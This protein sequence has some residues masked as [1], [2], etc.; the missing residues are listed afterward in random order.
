MDYSMIP[1]LN[2]SQTPTEADLIPKKFKG[3]VYMIVF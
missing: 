2:F 3:S 1:Q